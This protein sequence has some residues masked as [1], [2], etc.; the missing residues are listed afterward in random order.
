MMTL[1]ALLFI[2]YAL[3]YF[4]ILGFAKKKIVNSSKYYGLAIFL[5][6]IFIFIIPQLFGSLLSLIIGKEFIIFYINWI[7][8]VYFMIFYFG[9]IVALTLLRILEFNRENPPLSQQN[10][11]NPQVIF[12]SVNRVPIVTEIDDFSKRKFDKMIYI[13]LIFS[14]VA[15]LFYGAFSF[16]TII[17]AILAIVLTI[18]ALIK[19]KQLKLY[20]TILSALVLLASLGYLVFMAYYML[21]LMGFLSSWDVKWSRGDLEK[22]I[23]KIELYK[24]QNGHWAE[25]LQQVFPDNENIIQDI[26]FDVPIHYK[27]SADGRSYELWST[28]KDGVD[29]TKDDIYPNLENVDRGEEYMQDNIGY[30]DAYK[31]KYGRY[32]DTLDQA[33]QRRFPIL[34]RDAFDMPYYYKVSADGQSYEMRILGPDG[35]YGTEDDIT[36]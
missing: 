4:F 18:M 5:A 25:N 35:K 14:A 31:N 23:P 21:N 12:S 28:G 20:Q 6:F 17:L 10:T 13:A 16:I 32:P 29:G 36:L 26:R 1:N 11:V 7:A 27:V 34:T 3:T 30:L 9:L 8:A 33:F 19:F 24:G 2:I 22:M 15:W